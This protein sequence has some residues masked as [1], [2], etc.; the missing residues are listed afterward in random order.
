MF[1]AYLTTFAIFMAAHEFMVHMLLLGNVPVPRWH[2]ERWAITAGLLCDGGA[3]VASTLALSL[4]G[5]PGLSIVASSAMS[6]IHLGYVAWRAVSAGSFFPASDLDAQPVR[7]K[8]A[9]VTADAAVHLASLSAMVMI[10]GPWTGLVI[11][12]MASAA[13]LTRVEF[14]EPND[15]AGAGLA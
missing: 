8:A 1:V 14:S 3:H 2:R 13:M 10:A 7:A 11:A 6:A 15:S 9:L 12:G 4:L 5:A